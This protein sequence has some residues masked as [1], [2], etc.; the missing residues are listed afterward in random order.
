[1][2]VLNW[3]GFILS[4]YRGGVLAANISEYQGAVGAAAVE[5]SA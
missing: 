4:N 5:S 2:L 3:L 1:M